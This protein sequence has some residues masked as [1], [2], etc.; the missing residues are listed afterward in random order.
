MLLISSSI[1]TVLPTPAPPNRP[2]LPPLANGQIRSMTLMPVSSSSTDGDSSSN[3]G[4]RLVDPAPLF[5]LDRAALVDRATEHVHDAPEHARADRHR[6]VV[7]GV[8]DLHAALQAVGR[9]HRDRADH[10]VAELLLDLER[11]ALLD[12]LVAGVLL[13]HQ[14]VVDVRHRVARELDVDDRADALNDGPGGYG[15]HVCFLK[16]R[17]SNPLARAVPVTTLPRRRPQSRKSLW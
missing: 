9:T 11:Q 10:A 2:I 3:F 17:Y 16:S 8:A 6:D 15:A 5:G 14:R 12:E 13:Q 4:R 1:V 7:A